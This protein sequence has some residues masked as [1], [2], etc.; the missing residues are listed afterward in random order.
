MIRTCIF[1]LV[2]FIFVITLLNLFS[3]KSISLESIV[4]SIFV[5]CIFNSMISFFKFNLFGDDPT[6]KFY[7]RVFNRGYIFTALSFILLLVL[8]VF[9]MPNMET[10]VEM[11]ALI[12]L[13]TMCCLEAGWTA[14]V[15]NHTIIWNRTLKIYR[16]SEKFSYGKLVNKVKELEFTDRLC[17]KVTKPDA[18]KHYLI[19][20]FDDLIEFCE[21]ENL[22]EYWTPDDLLQ[23]DNY[24]V[25][26]VDASINLSNRVSAAFQYTPGVGEQEQ[27]LYSWLE[28]HNKGARE[29]INSWQV[30][31]MA[32]E[33]LKKHKEKTW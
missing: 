10:V 9:Y 32:R 1:Q 18:I 26:S 6:A 13:V 30:Y 2:N 12:F 23:N 4:L 3:L 19:N 29:I 8:W 27:L 31:N 20:G 24:H 17:V 33:N 16:G 15:A 25:E 14:L 7:L 22:G 5:Y 28:F 21:K 11:V